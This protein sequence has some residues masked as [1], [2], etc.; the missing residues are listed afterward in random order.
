MTTLNLVPKDAVVIHD[1]DIRTTSLKVAEAFGKRHDNVIA[2]L[3]S[4][5]CSPEFTALNFKV[6][7]YQD[8]TGRKMPMYE[9]TKDGF[10]F[11]VM[12]FTG[13]QAAQIKEAYINAFNA[14]A[15]TLAAAGSA[16]TTDDRTGLRNAVNLLVSKRGLM[17]SDAYS[18]IHHRFNVSHLDDLKR[19]Q[20]PKAV[21]YVH[22]LILEGDLIRHDDPAIPMFESRQQAIEAWQS[23]KHLSKNVEYAKKMFEELGLMQFLK[24]IDSG[25]ARILL[26]NIT[27][28]NNIASEID[29]MYKEAIGSAS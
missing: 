8:A 28:A 11:L 7:E 4:L 23:F 19:D 22:R 14:M 20:L 27:V 24:T 13:K 26:A 17:Y 3:K 18:L 15:A 2:K 9:M 29:A 10:M 21:E 12:G 25:P 1:A 6:S 16:T 5:D